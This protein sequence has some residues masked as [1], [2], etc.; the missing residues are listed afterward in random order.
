MPRIILHID[1]DAFFVSCE[2]KR[3]PSLKG[4]PAVVG[5]DP[6][7]GRGRGVVST[8]NYEAR[9]FGIHSGMPISKAYSLCPKA[10]FLIPDFHYYSKISKN[11]MKILRN[12][13][14]RFQ[15]V[16][17]DEAFL[18]ITEKAGDFEKAK[19]IG[20]EIKQEIFEKENLTCSIG[21]SVNKLVAKIASDLYKPC[22]LIVV[23][24]YEISPF[25]QPLPIRKLY[26]VGPKTEQKLKA[27]GI[28]TIGNLAQ[29]S[30]EKLMSHF[31]V[32]WLYMI[33]S[34]QG[35]GSD[36]VAEIYGRDSISRERTFFEDIEDFNKLEREIE[37]IGTFLYQD[38]NDGGYSYKTVSIKVRLHDFRT[39]TRART[40]GYE[41]TQDR[42]I[43]HTAKLLVREFE[44]KKVR[45]IG[46][47]LSNL[48]G[49]KGQR[50]IVE[51]C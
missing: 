27:L 7:E 28:E 44:G 24:E 5:A 33:L 31:V 40:L 6:K 39:Y 32:Y 43:I 21:I 38:L 36:F 41:S 48:K 26:G 12:Y 13:S 4:K 20:F 11:I 8:C 10:T 47:R 42:E 34:A 9:K 30:K 49:R 35:Q 22:S 18:D 16:S 17:I 25:L 50:S 19:L 29:S 3:S 15:Q 37:K 23:K 46:V 45:L 51:F 14:E 2:E 1:M